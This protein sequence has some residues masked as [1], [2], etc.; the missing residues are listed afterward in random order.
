[1]YYNCNIITKEETGEGELQE[2]GD[3]S[4]KNVNTGEQKWLK[5]KLADN[6]SYGSLPHSWCAL[7]GQ[8]TIS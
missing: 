1:M 2:G 3:D 5:G 8:C 6:T 7:Y 4:Y